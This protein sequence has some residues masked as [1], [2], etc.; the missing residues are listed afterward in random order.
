VVLV[1]DYHLALLPQ[2]IRE[3]LPKA[4][5]ITFWHI[6]WPNP[7][8][9]GI[10][11]WREEIIQGLLGSTIIGFHTR[12]HCSNFL[13]TVDRFLETRIEHESSTVHAWRPPDA[14][15]ELPDL[16]RVAAGPVGRAAAFGTA[17]Q[18]RADDP[19]QAVRRRFGLPDDHCI[20]LGVDRLDYTKGIVERIRAVEHLFERH[21]Q[22]IGRLTFVQI[23]APT[24]SSLD[25]YQRFEARCAPL[26]LTSTRASATPRTSR[27]SCWSST[28]TPPR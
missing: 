25:E 14:G 3:R 12:Y 9:F 19:H 8:S 4:T 20:A 7:E 6:P 21:P 15:G 24:R 11:P 10:C 18:R 22:W 26:R 13:Q 28:T 16:D 17:R 1:Q 27:S 5:I 2:M 23:A